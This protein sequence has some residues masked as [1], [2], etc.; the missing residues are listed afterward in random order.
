M[1]YINSGRMQTQNW[2]LRASEP[3]NNRQTA[4]FGDG[5][6]MQRQGPP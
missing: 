4:I 1:G 2:V 3:T 6:D 5:S